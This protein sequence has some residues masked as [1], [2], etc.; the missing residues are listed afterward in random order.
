MGRWGR[1]CA[2]ACNHDGACPALALLAI[3][4]L[5]TG[6]VPAAII[7]AVPGKDTPAVDS[8]G[9]T[10]ADWTTAAKRAPGAPGTTRMSEGLPED[11]MLRRRP[12][13]RASGRLGR[14]AR[15]VRHGSALLRL[16]RLYKGDRRPQLQRMRAR[17]PIFGFGF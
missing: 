10:R 6:R 1:I 16:A 5:K 2:A 15:S 14:P 11:L 4:Q 13:R 7:R 9:P 8:G 12:S 3:E 17:V